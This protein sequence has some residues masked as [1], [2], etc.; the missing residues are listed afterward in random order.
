MFAAAPLDVIKNSVQPPSLH[1]L[2]VDPSYREQSGYL[3]PKELTM[4]N[5]KLRFALPRAAIQKLPVCIEYHM[6]PVNG[7]PLMNTV[8]YSGTDLK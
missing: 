4:L 8:N 5:L 2:Y 1:V 3:K 7:T 6:D